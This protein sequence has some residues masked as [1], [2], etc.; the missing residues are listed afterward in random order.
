M[1]HH[2]SFLSIPPRGALASLALFGAS[3]GLVGCVDPGQRFDDFNS[4]IVDGGAGAGT[5]APA[6]DTLPDITGHFYVAMDPDP[7]PG[8]IFHLLAEVRFTDNGDGTGSADFSLQPLHKDDRTPVGDPLVSEGVVV[9]A[10]GRFDAPFAGDIDGQ[11]NP[12]TGSTLTVE[13]VLAG[14][15]LDENV[16]CGVVNGRI[17]QPL[18][19]P[20]DG[21]TF[22]AIRVEAGTEGDAL[23]EPAVTCP[24]PGE[25]DEGED[26]DDG[27][28][29]DEDDDEDDDGDGDDGG[30]DG[31]DDED[32]DDDAD[33]DTSGQD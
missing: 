18:I 13:L 1:K 17:T 2:C 22:A 29:G 4:R 27:E 11:A 21:S 7:V 5:D 12:A 24:E 20:L 32:G 9:D 10:T 6:F 3:L 30:D 25:E 33:T 8:A 15:I 19:L 31:G 23:P 28:P 16:W 26:E 14:A